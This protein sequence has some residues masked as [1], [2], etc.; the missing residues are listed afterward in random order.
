MSNELH[1]NSKSNSNLHH[2]YKIC[3]REENGVYK[4]GI[5]GRTLNSDN[6]SKR[7][8]EQVA[9]FNRVVGWERFYAVVIKNDIEGR[10]VALEIEKNYIEKYKSEKGNYPRGN[11]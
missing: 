10:E 6:S 3:D 7:A 11:E 1:G 8:N 4:F 2:L 5:C 9:L